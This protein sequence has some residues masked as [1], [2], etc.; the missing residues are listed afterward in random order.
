MDIIKEVQNR[1]SLFQNFYDIVRIVDPL[2]KKVIVIDEKGIKEMTKSCYALWKKDSFCSNC[3]SMRAFKEKDTFFKF[4]RS[5][6]KTFLI[7]ATPVEAGDN[8]LVV[9]I[10]KEVHE[11]NTMYKDNGL[12]AYLNESL[13]NINKKIIT[14]ELVGI[15][16]RRYINERLPVD[17]NKSF[18]NKSP[19]SIIMADLDHFKTVN[20][21]Y[22]HI[23]G[24][25]IL[26]DVAEVISNNIRNTTDWV[27]RYG[28]EEFLIVLN[29]TPLE[30][31][32]KVAE[33]IRM[34]L[35]N[36]TF[37]YG[38]ISINI[39]SSFGI[40]EIS[41]VALSVD[42]AIFYADKNLYTAKEEGRNRSCG[43]VFRE[44]NKK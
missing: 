42:D 44:E 18:L 15:Y 16:N 20:D 30:G 17:M 21:T 7:T 23:Y 24:D 13:S 31:A 37:H 2:N 32:Y 39:T 35:E 10:L 38:D 28:G 5:D 27:G 3:V 25:K 43:S 19:I 6:D 8:L 22:G 11:N 40:L 41:G 33:K 14:D 29:N 9:E 12:M 34:E 4:E 1:L 26:K 36:N